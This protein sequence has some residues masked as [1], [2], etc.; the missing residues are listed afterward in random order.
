MPLICLAFAFSQ[1]TAYGPNNTLKIGFNNRA[2]YLGT[3]SL[4]A[5]RGRNVEIISAPD[6]IIQTIC[7]AWLMI[8]NG[9][10]HMSLIWKEEGM[11]KRDK[12]S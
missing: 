10:F 7:F 12:V 4:A 8:K 5:V 1:G 9:V 11:H 2:N 3:N 6:V